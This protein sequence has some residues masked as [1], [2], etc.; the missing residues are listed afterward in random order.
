[1]TSTLLVLAAFRAQ[2]AAGW[3]AAAAAIAAT[4]AAFAVSRRSTGPSPALRIDADGRIS[5]RRGDE[6]APAEP[7]FVSP[8]LIC[9]RAGPRLLLPVWRDS[10][11]DAGYR[12]LAA[13]GRWQR[14]RTPEADPITGGIA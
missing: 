13:A 12:R 1:M 14:R 7:L 11:D 10:L 5:T 8:W 9:L 6:T 3:A 4:V 2:T